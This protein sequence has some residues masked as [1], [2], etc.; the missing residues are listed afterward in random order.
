[1]EVYTH[2]GIGTMLVDEKLEELREAGRRR[3]RHLPLI[4]PFEKTAR[5][6]SATAP[7][8]SRTSSK[9]PS[10]STMASFSGALRCIPI[11]RPAPQK[12]PAHHFP[13]VQGQ[14]DGRESSNASN[15]G[16]AAGMESL[17]VLTTRTMHW[18]IKRG[19]KW[20]TRLAARGPQTKIQLGPPVTSPRQEAVTI[21]FLDTFHP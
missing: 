16:Q 11:P 8:S 18:F 19:F 15:S 20:S 6:S 3:R 2:D 17:F 7:R 14:G 21:S 13:Q 4:E 5:W 10:S 1:M 12:W 9:P